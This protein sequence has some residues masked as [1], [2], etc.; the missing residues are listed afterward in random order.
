MSTELP[1]GTPGGKIGT[2][3]ADKLFRV[4]LKDGDPC[5]ILLHL[6]F[7]NQVHAI[8][9]K[10][11]VVYNVRIW[12]HYDCEVA[13]MAILG[14]PRTSWHPSA[15]ERKTLGFCHRVA[16][17]TAKLTDFLTIHAARLEPKKRDKSERFWL[18]IWSEM[19]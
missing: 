7:Q 19:A 17:P 15:Y 8:F 11:M 2:R 18:K 16:F 3:I 9:A 13:S 5:V 12:L 1:P 14:D 4:H 10:R 6:E